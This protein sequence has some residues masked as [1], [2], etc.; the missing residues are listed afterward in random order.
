MFDIL[1]LL[2]VKH[3][4]SIQIIETYFQLYSKTIMMC[5][6]FWLFNKNLFKIQKIKHISLQNL[7]LYVPFCLGILSF[8]A[9]V[10]PKD[11]M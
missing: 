11:K 3:W 5:F 10:P 4:C 7:K 8:K 6:F 1:H 2:F 9:T